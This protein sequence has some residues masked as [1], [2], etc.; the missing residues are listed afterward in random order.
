MIHLV[1]HAFPTPKNRSN[2]VF[3]TGIRGRLSQMPCLSGQSMMASYIPYDRNGNSRP[4]N[5]RMDS[6]IVFSCYYN[7]LAFDEKSKVTD[8]RFTE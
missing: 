8:K 2:E 4:G 6:S 5:G 3:R 1:E 7:K